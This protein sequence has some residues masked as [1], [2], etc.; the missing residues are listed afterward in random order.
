MVD[1]IA[2]LRTEALFNIVT[3][4]SG[5]PSIS[6]TIRFATFLDD[7]ATTLNQSTVDIATAEDFSVER[8]QALPLTVE[9]SKRVDNIDELLPSFLNA[10]AKIAE[11]QKQI[12][13]LNALID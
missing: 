7:L 11:L 2:P 4:P 5:A 8:Q 1:V 9:L 6:T 10:N 13:N 3:L 12:D